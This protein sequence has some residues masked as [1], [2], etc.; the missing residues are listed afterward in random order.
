MR[1][2]LVFLI[3]ILFAGSLYGQNATGR[4]IGTVLDPTGAVVGGAKITVTNTR[5]GASRETTS[6]KEGNY[7]VLDLV[8]GIYR[9]S[10]EKAGFAKLVTGEQQLLIGQT[11]RIDLSMSVGSTSETVDVDATVSSVE[12]VDST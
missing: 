8:I 3:A 11:L 12:T 6:D 5:T 7:Q 4:I 9:V 2:A 10:A 1:K